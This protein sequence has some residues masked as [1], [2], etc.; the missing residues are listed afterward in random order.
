MSVTLVRE[1]VYD[2]TFVEKRHSINQRVNSGVLA[3][4]GIGALIAAL[5]LEETGSLLVSIGV[6][7][8]GALTAAV[9]LPIIITCGM[10]GLCV[11]AAAVPII[12]ASV[13]MTAV[14]SATAS[15]VTLITLPILFPFLIIVAL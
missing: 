6:L 5:S 14:I 13:F 1:R 11:M 8:A 9:A 12:V 15:L 2:A 7:S 4:L 10:I 3:V